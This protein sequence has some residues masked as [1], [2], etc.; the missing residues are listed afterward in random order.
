MKNCDVCIINSKES[1]VGTVRKPEWRWRGDSV[2]HSGL[3][4]LQVLR[5]A[6]CLFKC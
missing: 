1:V 4:G 5:V 6:G 2:L 3:G